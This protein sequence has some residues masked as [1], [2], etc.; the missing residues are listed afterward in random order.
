MTMTRPWDCLVLL[1]IYIC[2]STEGLSSSGSHVCS[3]TASTSVSYQDKYT[4]SCGFIYWSRCNHYR[5]KYR[6]HSWTVYECCNGWRSTNGVDCSTA[7]CYGKDN[8]NGACNQRGSCVA[9]DR[10]SCHTG[11][12]GSQCDTCLDSRGDENHSIWW[13][14]NNH[15]DCALTCSWKKQ[16]CW[17]G[18]C[19]DRRLRTSC[20]CRKGFVKKDGG[21][22]YTKCDLAD[23]P[24]LLTCHIGMTDAHNSTKNST[25]GS[26]TGCQYESDTY[27]NLKPK[28]LYFLFGSTF[29]SIDITNPPNYVYDQE[30]GIVASKLT[31]TKIPI[32]GAQSSL[33]T[34]TLHGGNDCSEALGD[35]TPSHYLT[36]SKNLP[37]S[38]DMHDGERICLDFSATGGGFFKYQDF[39]RNHQGTEIYSH[40]TST[41]QLCFRYDIGKPVHCSMLNPSSCVS[42]PLELSTRITRTGLFHIHTTGWV[43][44]IPKGGKSDAAS[45]L[46][47]TKLQVLETAHK[48]NSIDVI[49]TPLKDL[50][51]KYDNT[52]QLD[53]PIQLPM[54]DGLYAV[55][56]EVHDKAGN[57]QSVRR[58]VLYDSSSQ[59]MKMPTKPLQVVSASPKTGYKWQTNFGHICIDYKGRYYNDEMRVNNPLDPVSHQIEV[60]TDYDQ[61]AGILPISGTPNVDGIIEAKYSVSAD[62]AAQSDWTLVPHFT[63]QS[64]C[65]SNKLHDGQT[66]NI[67][68]QMTDIVNNSLV[69][70]VWVYIDSTVPDIS[71]MWLVKDGNK[72]VYVHDSLDL[73]TMVLQFDVIDPHSGVNTVEWYLGTADSSEDLGHGVLPSGKLN[74]T[75]C[76]TNSKCYCPTIG[77][78]QLHN[79]TVP[80]NSLVA[81]KTNDAQHNQAFYFTVVGTNGAD[82]RIIDH[83]DI[84]VDAS[85]PEAGIVK[86]GAVDGPDVDYTSEDTVLVNW[87]GFIDHESGINHYLV[88]LAPTCLTLD[89]MKNIT[90]TLE[91]TEGINTAQFKIRKEMNKYYA[92]VV[93]FNAALS[94]STPSCSD[95]IIRDIS[96]PSV[97]N[98]TLSSAQTSQEHV[99]CLDG[100]LWLVTRNLTRSLLGKTR[101][102]AH[103]CKSKSTSIMGQMLP[104]SLNIL[105]DT[106]I[107]D[108]YCR[109][110]PSFDG[111]LIFLPSDKIVY[112][113]NCSEMESQMRDFSVG[114]GS[115]KS[116]AHDPDILDYAS[117]KGHH[118]FKLNHVGIAGKNTFYIFLKAMNKAG[119]SS[120]ATFGPVMIDNTPPIIT[121]KVLP[122]LSGKFVIIKWNND[123]FSD[124]EQDSTFTVLFRIMHDGQ[125]V[126]PILQ[127]PKQITESCQIQGHAGCIRYP[128]ERLQEMD[129]ELNKPFLFELYVYNSAGHFTIV[130]T[131]KITVP[132][133]FPPGHGIVYDIDPMHEGRKDDVD[134]H[135]SLKKSC[136]RWSG[137]SH[138]RDVQFEVALGSS[139]N[140]S[141]ISPFRVANGT[142]ICIT[143][144]SFKP[145]IKYYATV[146]ATCSGGSSYASSDGFIIIDQPTSDQ[147][148]LEVF[149]GVACGDQSYGTS[150]LD[151]ETD[152]ELDSNFTR[153]YKPSA[154]LHIGHTYIVE[155]EHSIT[156]NIS[157][158]DVLLMSNINTDAKKDL[159]TYQFIPLTHYPRFYINSA[160]D[161]T[162]STIHMC[163]LDSDYTL[164]KNR[165]S[166]YWRYAGPWKVLTTHFEA[167]L[168]ERMHCENRT[169]CYKTLST[170]IVD[171]GTDYADFTNMVLEH[172]KVYQVFVRPCF[173]TVCLPWKSSDGIKVVSGLQKVTTS[174]SFNSSSTSSCHAVTIHVDSVKCEEEPGD[175]KTIIYQWAASDKHNNPFTSWKTD[176]SL[177]KGQSDVCLEDQVQSHSTINICV[178][179]ICPSGLSDTSCQTVHHTGKHGNRLVEVDQKDIQ[180]IREMIDKL[181]TRNLA[182]FD[183]DVAESKIKL[184]GVRDGI[185]GRMST[186]Y[187]MKEP[188][189]PNDCEADDKCITSVDAVGPVAYFHGLELLDSVKYYIC[190]HSVPTG[191]NNS[192]ISECGDGVIIDDLPPTKG[193]VHVINQ[194]NGFLTEGDVLEIAWSGFSDHELYFKDTDSGIAHFSYAIGTYPG[195]QDAQPFTRVGLVH[196]A[197]ISKIILENG[198]IYYAT[199]K[200]YD[201][202]GHSTSATSDAA[203]V[204]V[205]PPKTGDIFIGDILDSHSVVSGDRLTVHWAGFEDPESGILSTYLSIGSTSTG[206]LSPFMKY[207]GTFA[208]LHMNGFIDGHEYYARIMVTN[209]AGLTSMA[210]SNSFTVD[211]SPPTNGVVTDGR[212][213]NQVELDY[214]S[215]TDRYSCHWSGFDDPHSG[216]SSF[217]VSLGTQPYL[218]DVETE[219]HVGLGTEMSWTGDLPVGIK[220]Y[221]SVKACNHAGRCSKAVSDGIILDNS[222]P[223]PGMVFVGH[224]GHH[225]KYHGHV[226]TLPAR[227]FGFEDPDT[228]I[229]HFDWCI[230]T[231]SRKCDVLPSINNLLSDSV[232]KTGLKLPSGH[233]LY[234]TVNATNPAG[235]VATSTSDSFI[236]DASP[237]VATQKPTFTSPYSKNMSAV[238]VQ[239][240]NSM[241]HLHW[242]FTD[243]DSPIQRHLVSL[244]THHDGASAV[245]SIH[246]GAQDS[247]IILFE[248]GNLMRSGDVYTATVT[249]C[250]AAGLCSTAT[251]N[252]I[253]IDSTPPQMGGFES[254][255]AWEEVIEQG[256]TKTRFDLRWL[257]F[258][259]A[260]SGIQSYHISVS[261]TYDGNELSRGIVQIVHDMYATKQS[262]SFILSDL[263]RT[264]ENI[265]LTISATNTAGLSSTVGK[266]TMAVVATDAKHTK[267]TLEL[268][269]HSCS[270]H[271]CTGDCTCAVFGQRCLL[272]SSQQN[273]TDTTSKLKST[274]IVV[275]PGLEADTTVTSS[276]SC[277]TAHWEASSSRVLSSITRFQWSIGEKGQNPGVGIFDFKTETVWREIEK[278]TRLIHCLP[279]GRSLQHGTEYIAQVKAWF[280][281]SDYAVFQSH[282]FLVDHT[283]PAVQRAKSLLDSDGSC[284]KDEEYFSHGQTITACWEGVFNDTQTPL[285]GFE[286]WIG[287]SPEGDDVI[288]ATSMGNQT[289]FTIPLP[290]LKS[291]SKY[292][293]SIRATNL[294]G[295]QTIAVSDGFVVDDTPPVVGIVFNTDRH[296]NIEFQSSNTTL[297]ASWH[298]FEDYHSYVQRFE[299]AVL[300]EGEHV[301]DSMF[302]Y[303]GMENEITIENLTLEEKKRYRVAVRAV[304]AAGIASN[305]AESPS[306]LIDTSSPKAFECTS[307]VDRKVNSTALQYKS[308]RHGSIQ[309]HVFE[310]LLKDTFYRMTLKGNLDIHVSRVI[311]TVGNLQFPAKFE[312]KFSGVQASHS[313]LASRS[314]LSNISISITGTTVSNAFNVTLGAC[315]NRAETDPTNGITVRQIRPSVVA[316]CARVIDHESGT[317]SVWLGAGTS[318]G[319]Y[320]IRALSPTSVSNHEMILVEEPHGSPVHVTVM[321]E[322]NAGLR[323]I[324]T[325]KP[326]TID[327]TPPDMSVPSGTLE[328]IVGSDTVSTLMTWEVQDVESGVHSCLCTYGT[329]PLSYDD[330]TW[331]RSQSL[332]HCELKNI[333]APHDSV[334]FVWARCINNVNLETVIKSQLLHVVYHPP[335]LPIGSL[336]LIVDNQ[337]SSGSLPSNVQGY[338][339]HVEFVWKDGDTS[340]VGSYECRLLEHGTPVADWVSMGQKTYATLDRLSLQDGHVYEIQ[341]RAVNGRVQYSNILNST[342]TV[343]SRSPSTTGAEPNITLAKG[344]LMVDWASVFDDF[345]MKTEYEVSVGTRQGFADIV[346]QMSTKDTYLTATT[347]TNAPGVFLTIKAKSETGKFGI[348]SHFLSLN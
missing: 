70:S 278:R 150:G 26:I 151:P 168:K 279:R 64:L 233:P 5:T 339:D 338:T 188:H 45:G 275:H 127:T 90:E 289:S 162:N 345:N 144:S 170:I 139:A 75:T 257:G 120:V 38:T 48:G 2:S 128:L 82:L 152:K 116:T 16:W 245:E 303:Q 230:G 307:F 109:D 47:F 96:P 129:S 191:Q 187:L 195:G 212:K 288:Q 15:P 182:S 254:P 25:S 119:L 204:D 52:F 324:F 104:K 311:F 325:S 200:A 267:G 131:E 112:H 154:S 304:D 94:P 241:L 98:I 158:D 300:K 285:T 165:V 69:E 299:I 243:A 59:L 222:P 220:L 264:G 124:Q 54:K 337:I 42:Q 216:L 344:H 247:T 193:E 343:E 103:R 122:I 9:P 174:S 320:Q 157:M 214:Q 29:D 126:T 322:N 301:L 6:I 30:Y 31:L 35:T 62:H 283:P 167:A 242:K 143:S 39:D 111:S 226:S 203:L 315:Q 156:G 194:Q 172:G 65:I 334:L 282:S 190:I 28:S 331:R 341:V 312:K 207:S 40:Q 81:N 100:D 263:I 186:W 297:K 17:P 102:C 160:D 125:R 314:G 113:W 177:A 248:A 115:D 340:D 61:T 84:L 183:T 163:S 192:R 36:C 106:E 13:N 74:G 240:E 53:K 269:R 323:T 326:I 20:T 101:E 141:D 268:Q 108:S 118:F 246:L 205:T 185:E 71:N 97:Y 196:N 333:S 280:S 49:H 258:V 228:G 63:N 130:N 217:H 14:T 164:S 189:I 206:T 290:L 291:G 7:I 231:S 262:A 110:L 134:F 272:T 51:F 259:D 171:S 79:Y 348:Y 80:L 83:L 211:T 121:G 3:H 173:D 298:G 46:I 85:P 202:L 266:V 302:K 78:C 276:S 148:T 107:D 346:R 208:D 261:R 310:H 86:E 319:G 34:V 235:L 305:T 12:T 265:I 1:T 347:D 91:V 92:T 256:V 277:L 76:P 114:F 68:L 253:R 55:I 147:F 180:V 24:Q 197:I 77:E 251:S 181:E 308:L 244:S 60:E 335:A 175:S 249:A 117:S 23:K 218:D 11:Y 227:W 142:S 332:T 219:T 236:V 342:I 56:L 239:W 88:S 140:G 274:D 33:S 132:S 149:D 238:N 58:L 155:F 161:I 234:V 317:R 123:T 318:K 93:A 224:D 250:N 99:V 57:I 179:V 209:Q 294:A 225:H 313:F 159:D 328:Y 50:D 72:Q 135:S 329:H 4:S 66:F 296:K 146:R 336:K 41:K 210:V 153:V 198:K 292:Y 271:Y 223:V 260:E 169:Q 284:K 237:P 330:H 145:R 287:T 252:Q 44:P 286:V 327:H 281:F 273:C 270:V 87:A 73:S 306:V 309:L 316:V 133:R 8:T 10:C 21:S 166:S 18:D 213:T 27:V 229:Y 136:V 43:D 199:V 255:M 295:L 176:Q 67:S 215:Y 201:R 138:H 19:P 95:G 221:C 184:A 105:N 32:T 321:A 22:S 232:L 178:R 37:S 89:E 137:F 293:S